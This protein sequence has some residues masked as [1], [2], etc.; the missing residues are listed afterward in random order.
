VK[1]KKAAYPRR[2]APKPL[3]MLATV[4]VKLKSA[5]KSAYCVAAC[6]FWQARIR[7]ARKAAVPRPPLKLS[8]ADAA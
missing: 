8:T 6:S 1:A 7:K 3:A 4:R 5:D 2:S